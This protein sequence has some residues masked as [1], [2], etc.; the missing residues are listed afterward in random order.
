M[1]FEVAPLG[2]RVNQDIRV[3]LLSQVFLR[4]GLVASRY[5]L[6]TGKVLGSVPIV[7]I[8]TTLNNNPNRAAEMAQ[9]IKVFAAKPTNMSSVFRT[10]TVEEKNSC[11][12]SSD[13]HICDTSMH[14]H[15]CSHYC[16]QNVFK[17]PPK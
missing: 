6:S 8:I 7:I 15:M 13:L 4:T 3:E 14:T 16:A 1:C 5:K 12:L 9:W 17:M 2:G 10:P 11:K